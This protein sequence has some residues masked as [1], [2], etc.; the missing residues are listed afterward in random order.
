MF[1][2][3]LYIF[4]GVFTLLLHSYSLV[5]SEL[6]VGGAWVQLES[7]P[8]PSQVLDLFETLGGIDTNFSFFNSVSQNSDSPIMTVGYSLPGFGVLTVEPETNSIFFIDPF[9]L[10]S[11]DVSLKDFQGRLSTTLFGGQI[12]LFAEITDQPS[13]LFMG[14]SSSR[15]V[16]ASLGYA[17]F[18]L[19]GIYKYS[20]K[21]GFFED[22]NAWQA[23]LGYGSNDFGLSL[24]YIRAEGG[25][26]GVMD[27]DGK[28]WMIGG[29]MQISSTVLLDANAFY[30]YRNQSSFALD[31]P[32]KG[33]RL[34]VRLRF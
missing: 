34:G 21:N 27:L 24:T 29:L 8:K 22:I 15:T 3:K 23:G 16:G 4:Y 31:P 17:G 2:R 32:D 14:P 5:A 6:S 25:H 19:S 30:S 18:Y 26:T 10:R 7:K 9:D 20:E 33:A 11:S 1:K 28:R 12:G 13:G